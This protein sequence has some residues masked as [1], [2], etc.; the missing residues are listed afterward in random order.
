MEERIRRILQRRERSAIEAP[1]LKK[2]AVCLSL[3]KNGEEYYIL[4]TKRTQRVEYHKGQISF[5]GG[6]SDPEDPDLL[7]TCKRESF[8]EIGVR[9]EDIEILGG[10][11]DVITKTSNY[12]VS[13]FVATIPFP[14]RFVQNPFEISEI[15]EVPLKTL[16][17]QFRRGSG[18]Y[19]YKNHLIWGATSRILSQFLSLIE[20]EN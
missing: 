1:G 5:P 4:F 15:I 7:A 10:L 18:T 14:Y 16:L 13:P 12:I 19:S 17:E 2:A 9:V 3:Y 8:E 6:A 20:K 11:D